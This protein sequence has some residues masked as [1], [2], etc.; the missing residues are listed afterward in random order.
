MSFILALPRSEFLIAALYN[1]LI[2]ALNDLFELKKQNKS[3]N[4]NELK[5]KIKNACKPVFNYQF[6]CFKFFVV[7]IINEIY[8]G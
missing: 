7:Q 3:L 8:A 1:K 2:A 6:L 4:I 5:A